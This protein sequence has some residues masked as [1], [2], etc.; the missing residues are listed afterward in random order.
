[1]GNKNN[2]DSGESRVK[3]ILQEFAEGAAYTLPGGWSIYFLIFISVFSVV[4][5]SNPPIHSLV[6]SVLEPYFSAINIAFMSGL[7]IAMVYM[8][9]VTVLRVLAGPIYRYEKAGEGAGIH[10]RVAVAAGMPPKPLTEERI[11]RVACHEAG[12]LLAIRL[13]GVL[14]N[15]IKAV[16]KEY[17][18]PILGNVR[19]DFDDDFLCLKESVESSMKV[20][21]AGAIAE[22]MIFGNC[23]VGAQTDSEQ[24]ERQARN[25]LGAFDHNFAWFECPNTEAEAL[26]N[27]KTLHQ[28]KTAHEREVSTFLSEHSELLIEAMNVLFENKEIDGEVLLDMVE[29]TVIYQ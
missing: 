11:K 15:N 23:M 22:N 2:I 4:L 16:V 25:W 8:A 1:M 26:I 27:S 18:A 13:F 17:Q 3:R 28:I 7:T 10:E 5:Y 6:N 24:W 14:P 9:T 20:T 29:K 12:H 19:Y 21:V